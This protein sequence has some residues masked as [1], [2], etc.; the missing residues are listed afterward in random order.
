VKIKFKHV[1]TVLGFL[2]LSPA[3]GEKYDIVVGKNK[4]P[5]VMQ[6]GDKGFEI[7]LMRAI[8]TSLGKDVN[9]LFAPYGRNSKI[10][11]NNIADA[12]M[13]M[14]SDL[15]VSPYFLSDVYVT[16]ENVAITQKKRNIKLNTSADLAN[17]TIYAFDQ[18]SKV[19][20]EE[21]AEAIMRSPNYTEVQDQLV[22]VRVLYAGK[23]DVVII[24]KNI[25]HHLSSLSGRLEDLSDIDIH[26]LFPKNQYSIAFKYSDEVKA[27]NTALATFKMSGQYQELLSKYNL[28]IESKS[29]GTN[30]ITVQ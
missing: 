22:Q 3:F 16:Y 19:L 7:E 28:T 1:C 13:T 10:F 6:N 23:V 18:S 24:E 30:L 9:F 25:F 11:E 2:F 8:F 27:F 21:Y 20:G 29:A 14:N 26:Y 15:V 17:Y 5:Y 4:P 12:I